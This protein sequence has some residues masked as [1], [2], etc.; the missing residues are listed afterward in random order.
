[1]RI[2]ISGRTVAYDRESEQEITD[3]GRLRLLN[4]IV[5]NENLIS[6]YFSESLVDMGIIGGESR[7]E[8]EEQGGY[9]CVISEFWA[10]RALTTEELQRLTEDTAGQWSDGIGEGGLSTTTCPDIIVDPYPTLGDHQ[11]LVE[12]IEDGRSIPRPAALPKAARN[13]D[14]QAITIALQSGEDINFRQQKYTPLHLAI[15]YCQPAAAQLLIEHGADVDALGP[16]SQTPLMFCAV[17]RDLTD[18]KAASIA[19][20]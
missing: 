8:F 14:L 5:F 18:E 11:L 15:L 1:M 7:L 2:A 17:T 12:Q 3:S 9:L 19:R 13:G 6:D 4:G 16:L 20:E 10:P